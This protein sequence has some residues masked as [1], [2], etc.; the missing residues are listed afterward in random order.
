MPQPCTW[1][2]LQN[3]S[4]TGSQISPQQVQKD[5]Y[6]NAMTLIITRKNLEPWNTWRL[7]SILLK[8][9]Y[10]NHEIKEEIK[11]I[12]G[13]QWKW[14]HDSLNP[15]ECSKGS[16]K[17][18]VYCNSG[19]YQEAQKVPNTQPNLT[20]K[21]VKEQW[22]KSKASRRRGIIKIRTQINNIEMNNNNNNKKLE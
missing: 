17:R 7:K 15:L 20:P 1:N 14:K 22:I 9:D 12:Y 2:I 3:R 13:S 6:H 21:N 4:H 8:N 19:L 5:W 18:E 10:F 11:N 16:P